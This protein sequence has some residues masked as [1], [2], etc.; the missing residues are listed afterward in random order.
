MRPPSI[1]LGIDL[2]GTK[3]EIM[4]LDRSGGAML[5]RRVETPKG[6]TGLLELLVELVAGREGAERRPWAG[7]G[8]GPYPPPRSFCR[9]SNERAALLLRQARL[10]GSV[11]FWTGARR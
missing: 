3:T 6:Y 4:A 9:R 10:P 2:G 5:R 1:R 8:I 11:V 7:R